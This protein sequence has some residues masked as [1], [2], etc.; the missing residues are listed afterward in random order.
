MCFG[1]GPSEVRERQT[2]REAEACRRSHAARVPSVGEWHVVMSALICRHMLAT[3]RCLV[4]ESVM[5]ALGVSQCGA[6]VSSVTTE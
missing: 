4:Y 1:G 2:T 5:D 3:H 6:H